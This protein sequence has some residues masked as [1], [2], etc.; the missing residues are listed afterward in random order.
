MIDGVSN[1]HGVPRAIDAKVL[2]AEAEPEVLLTT[3][4]NNKPYCEIVVAVA[5]LLREIAAQTKRP[6]G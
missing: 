6:P 1:G 5:D 4:V 3:Y 2:S